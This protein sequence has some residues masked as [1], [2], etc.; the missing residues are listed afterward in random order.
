MHSTHLH[1]MSQSQSQEE[2]NWKCTHFD[3]LPALK[4]KDSHGTAPLS[5]DVYGL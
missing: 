2:P 1:I 5:W 3:I 4:G